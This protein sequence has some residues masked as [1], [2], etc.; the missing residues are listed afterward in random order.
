MKAIIALMVV[1]LSVD[2]L[3]PHASQAM[4]I[5]TI[6]SGAIVSAGDPVDTS[7]TFGGEGFSVDGINRATIVG[8]TIFSG[9]FSG[10][11]IGLDGPRIL[12]PPLSAPHNVVVDGVGTCDGVPL[13]TNCGFIQL[14]N[15]PAQ[16]TAEFDFRHYDL[17]VPFTATGHLD[18]GDGFDI[19]GAGFLR[20]EFCATCFPNS[21]FQRWTYT[22]VVPEP[23]TWLL[24]ASGLMVLITCT[25][26]RRSRL[27]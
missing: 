24:L 27:R 2:A 10:L 8:Q 15:P 26:A 18:V 5:L 12:P 13:S 21:V 7:Y 25:V 14:A 4:K 3:L 9:G 19:I 20:A 16:L 22:F 1:L 23:F 11:T 17:S 6:Q